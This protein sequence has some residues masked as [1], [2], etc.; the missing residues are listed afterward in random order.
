MLVHL[1]TAHPDPGDD[2]MALTAPERHLEALKLYVIWQAAEQMEAAQQLN[3][4]VTAS[5][6]LLTSMRISA[7]RAR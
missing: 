2:V 4:D 7:D 6:D 1:E 5:Y 3:P